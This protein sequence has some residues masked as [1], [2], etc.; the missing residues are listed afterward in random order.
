[1]GFAERSLTT[2]RFVVGCA[3]TDEAHHVN[4][5]VIGDRH[6]GRWEQLAAYCSNR[7]E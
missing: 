6:V 2:S 5:A 1:M 7:C 3:S 4:I